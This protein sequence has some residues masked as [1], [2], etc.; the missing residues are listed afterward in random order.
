MRGIK[1]AV[2]AVITG[3]I[4]G[5]LSVIFGEPFF[6]GAIFSLLAL[7]YLDNYVDN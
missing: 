2:T 6:Y 5:T 1:I 3:T 7:I 4:L